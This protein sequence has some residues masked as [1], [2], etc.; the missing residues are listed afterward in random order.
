MSHFNAIVINRSHQKLEVDRTF[1]PSSLV[2]NVFSWVFRVSQIFSRGYFVGPR[3]FLVCISW[4]KNI[5]S[6]VFR[7]SPKFSPVGN[8][9]IFSCWSHGRKW[10]RNISQTI[11]GG[12]ILTKNYLTI[13]RRH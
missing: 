8:F 7:G 12:K 11:Y 5:F 9:V 10:H 13:K 2:Q 4:V 6:W 3:F 1:V